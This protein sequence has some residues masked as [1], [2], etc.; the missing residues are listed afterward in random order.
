MLN[1]SLLAYYYDTPYN[2]LMSI[3]RIYHV[4]SS[5]DYETGFRVAKAFLNIEPKQY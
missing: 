5:I 1:L 4:L 2:A 3:L